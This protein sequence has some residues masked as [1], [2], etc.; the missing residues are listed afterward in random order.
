MPKYNDMGYTYVAGNNDINFAKRKVNTVENILNAKYSFSNKMG[1][2]FRA[3]HYLST[4]DNKTFYLLQP[5]GKLLLNSRFYPDA[6]QNVNFFNIDMV[7]SWQFAPGSFLNIVW[8]N[9]TQHSTNEVEP[10]YF[11]NLGNTISSDNNN[12]FSL[13]VIYFLDFLTIQKQLSSHT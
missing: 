9:A 2:T 10:S 13:K 6:N 3:R 8:K 4:V 1:I 7:Y 12:N 5:D 11:K